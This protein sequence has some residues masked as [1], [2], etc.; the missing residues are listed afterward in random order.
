MID[1]PNLQRLSQDPAPKKIGARVGDDDQTTSC[2]IR[3]AKKP[4]KKKKKQQTSNKNVKQQVL[5]NNLQLRGEN[6]GGQ[7]EELCS[8]WIE[9]PP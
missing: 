7:Q 2:S 3:R 9:V 5:S 8:G 4:E 6:E 1:M